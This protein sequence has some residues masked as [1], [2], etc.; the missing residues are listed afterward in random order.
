MDGNRT[1]GP[2]G[3]SRRPFSL[4]EKTYTQAF[5]ALYSFKE[6]NHFEQIYR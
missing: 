4:L 1:S 6:K 2:A 5:P 3:E